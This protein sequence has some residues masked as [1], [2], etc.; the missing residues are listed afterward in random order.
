MM[1]G[2]GMNVF[3]R[4]LLLQIPGW[5]VVGV[6]AFSLERWAG[7]DWRIALG[8][9]V[10]YFAKDFLLY[11]LLRPAYETDVSSGAAALVGEAGTATE[12]LNPNGYVRVRGE[13]WHAELAAGVAPVR[14]GSRVRVRSA[15]GLT[16]TVAPD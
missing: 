11:P 16:L 14:A 15:R 3:R 5:I 4:Y 9:W 8:L 2:A 7:L 12:D 10:A 1:V 13:L 6:V